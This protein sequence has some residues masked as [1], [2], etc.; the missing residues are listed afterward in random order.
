M[1][2][3]DKNHAVSFRQ[4]AEN[5][6]RARDTQSIRGVSD[7]LA[8]GCKRWHLLAPGRRYG[9]KSSLW[10]YTSPPISHTQ[11]TLTLSRIK[12]ERYGFIKKCV[13]SFIE[14]LKSCLIM[15]PLIFIL[16]LY[17]RVRSKAEL[18]K[19]ENYSTAYWDILMCHTWTSPFHGLWLAAGL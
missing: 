5:H 17:N 14:V 13:R 16:R 19:Q 11:P 1:G 7:E 3:C 2:S 9:K 12:C 18:Q 6:S 8:R 4:S 15:F 10:V